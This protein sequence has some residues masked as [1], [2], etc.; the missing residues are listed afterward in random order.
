[1]ASELTDI[2][3]ISGSGLKAQSQRMKIVA[4]NVANA[5]TTASAP[6][7]RPYQ[8]Q[9]ITFKKE[10]DKALG[11]YKVKVDGVRLD[12]SEF[13]KK[14]DPSHPASDAQGYILQPNVNPLIETMD[15]SEASRSYQANLDVIASSRTMV[16]KTIGMLQ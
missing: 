6:G 12:N 7:Q 16:L 4:Q 10:F 13:V 2:F 9:V 5:N 1:M 15:M 8:R 3:A 14:Y 11:A